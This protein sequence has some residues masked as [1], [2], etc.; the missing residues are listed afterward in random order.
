MYQACTH[1]VQNVVHYQPRSPRE[2]YLLF[3]ST[4][5]IDIDFKQEHIITLTLLSNRNHAVVDTQRLIHHMTSFSTA[6]MTI[7]HCHDYFQRTTCS[8]YVSSVYGS[9]SGTFTYIYVR[10]G[11]DNKT[12][13]TKCQA[14]HCCLIYQFYVLHC[15][16]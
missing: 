15:E 11:P 3:R 8:I 10:L 2:M 6:S 13:Q 12:F 9:K 14:F 4:V 5:R 1:V 16:D 7:P